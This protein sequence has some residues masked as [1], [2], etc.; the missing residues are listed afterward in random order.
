L[1]I[2]YIFAL[3]TLFFFFA[4]ILSDLVECKLHDCWSWMVSMLIYI[5]VYFSCSMVVDYWA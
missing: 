1:T 2:I 5:S 4:T 3:A